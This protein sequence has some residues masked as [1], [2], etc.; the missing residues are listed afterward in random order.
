LPIAEWTSVSVL[1]VCGILYTRGN[2]VTPEENPTPETESIM[3]SALQ[4]PEKQAEIN[5][6]AQARLLPFV[7]LQPNSVDLAIR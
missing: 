6:L 5:D 7:K 2:A 1:K 3:P 4:S